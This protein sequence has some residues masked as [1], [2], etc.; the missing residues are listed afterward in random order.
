[1]KKVLIK[2][3]DNLEEG[4]ATTVISGENLFKDGISPRRDSPTQEGSV[5]ERIVVSHKGEAS[6]KGRVNREVKANEGEGGYHGV[7]VV[8]M[9][10]GTSGSRWVHSAMC[11]WPGAA[12]SAGALEPFSLPLSYPQRP[13]PVVHTVFT[14]V[15]GHR[16]STERTSVDDGDRDF[17]FVS[18][19]PPPV[20]RLLA[21]VAAASATSDRPRRPPGHRALA[22]TRGGGSVSLGGDFDRPTALVKRRWVTSSSRALERSVVDRRNPCAWIRETLIGAL[23]NYP[24]E[25]KAGRERNE[26]TE[27]DPRE[28]VENRRGVVDARG[29]AFAS[30]ETTL[31]NAS[32]ATVAAKKDR[33]VC[34]IEFLRTIEKVY[35]I[36]SA[37]SVRGESARDVFLPSSPR[38]NA[39]PRT[40]ALSGRQLELAWNVLSSSPSPRSDRR[41][42]PQTGGTVERRSLDF[43]S[44]TP[45]TPRFATWC[46]P[47]SPTL[48]GGN[49]GPCT[50]PARIRETSVRVRLIVNQA[51]ELHAGNFSSVD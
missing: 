36:R 24:P 49:P 35:P 9:C 30:K 48:R 11:S 4:E 16:G 21:T 13:Q 29:G 19:P 1:M 40:P 3:D 37:V 15:D 41:R 33:A 28:R 39:P 20:S 12:S 7:A 43:Y 45:L 38:W 42:R 2:S 50:A 27:R 26:L 31:E 25:G 51:G 47:R 5:C 18:P 32:S 44:V 46:N 34:E 22:A 14:V 8:R 17:S 10:G 6:S 23:V